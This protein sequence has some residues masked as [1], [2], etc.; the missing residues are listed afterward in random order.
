MLD[1]LYNGNI[2][3]E[4]IWLPDMKINYNF[5][6]RGALRPLRQLPSGDRPTAPGSATDPAYPAIP[7]DKRVREIALA[8]PDAPAI[9]EIADRA[10]S[11]Q[12]TLASVYG[13]TLAP[14]GADRLRTP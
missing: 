9:D 7:R 4:Q 5:S 14:H 12:A 6:E 1:A 8:T 13:F 10:G 3:L 2:K 11:P